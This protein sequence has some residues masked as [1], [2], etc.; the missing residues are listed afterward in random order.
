MND[1]RLPEEQKGHKAYLLERKH[2]RMKMVDECSSGLSV[3][4]KIKSS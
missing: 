1:D 3:A 2:Y 4:D